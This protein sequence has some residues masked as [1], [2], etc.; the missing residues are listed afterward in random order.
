MPNKWRRFEI[1]L[2]VR[3]NDGAEIPADWLG[4]AV[5]EVVEQFGAASF[6]TQ[7]IEGQ[8]RH[9]STLY[10]DTLGKLVV[11]VHDNDI[12]RQWMKSYRDR[13]KIRLKQIELW[14]VS[15]PITVE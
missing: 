2:P 6:E 9:A 12:N 14:L 13:W 5:T 8:W 4:E 10:R 11:D 15:Y 1:L 3:F 7:T